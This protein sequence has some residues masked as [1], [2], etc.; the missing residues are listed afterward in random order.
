MIVPYGA[1]AGE[2]VKIEF[3]FYS[4]QENITVRAHTNK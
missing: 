4:V 1:Y 2:W 3:F